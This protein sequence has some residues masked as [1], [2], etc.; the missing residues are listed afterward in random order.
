[1][2]KFTV[3]LFFAAT[4]LFAQTTPSLKAVKK[5]FIDKM[6]NDLDQYLR[7]EVVKQFK[8]KLTVVLDPKDAD[9]IL[10]GV[11][12][13]KKGTAAVVTG[14]YLGLHD[15]ATGTVSLTDRE[16]NVLLWADEAG[17]RSLFWGPLARGGPRKVAERLISK[18]KDAMAKAK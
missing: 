12:Q 16:G 10:T 13:E 9:G 4:C 14:R 15:N 5:I 17:D 18:L 7:A 3:V 11:N 6:D 8:G 1:M 2:K